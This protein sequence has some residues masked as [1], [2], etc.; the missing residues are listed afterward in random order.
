[1]AE[2]HV[3]RRA[4]QIVRQEL[5]GNTLQSQDAP[6]CWFYVVGIVGVIL[7]GWILPLHS[8]LWQ[9]EFGTFWIA[10][11]SLADM[12]FRASFAMQSPIYQFLPWAFMRLGRDTEAVMRL[13]STITA[14]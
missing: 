9:D 2:F 8:S 14:A 11:D 5:S 10:K 13:P 4:E 12:V 1:M 6:C 3:L 7:V